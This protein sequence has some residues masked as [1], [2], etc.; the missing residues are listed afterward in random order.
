MEEVVR[1]IKRRNNFL[2]L[3]LVFLK[4]KL[5]TKKELRLTDKLILHIK[6]NLNSRLLQYI[7]LKNAQT[8]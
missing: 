7:L 3:K 8:D 6:R 2:I 1:K 4:R 5:T